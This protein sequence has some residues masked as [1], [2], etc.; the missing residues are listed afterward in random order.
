[1]CS[2]MSPTGVLSFQAPR[3]STDR[4]CVY[5]GLASLVLVLQKEPAQGY[6]V[7]IVIVIIN[8]HL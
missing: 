5:S 3:P 8:E 7:T 6:C 2:L 1:M 4:P